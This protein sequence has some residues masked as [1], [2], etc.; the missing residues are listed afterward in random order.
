MEFLFTWIEKY[1]TIFLLFAVMSYMIPQETYRK[2][3]RFFMELVFVLLLIAPIFSFFFEG[4]VQR[5]EHLPLFYGGDGAEGEGG[6]EPILSG[7]R[8]YGVCDA[9]AGGGAGAG[10]R[11]VSLKKAF[12]YIRH[13]DKT[14]WLTV[15]LVGVLLLVVA[16]PVNNGTKDG[17]ADADGEEESAAESA[18]REQQ[19]YQEYLEQRLEDIL[20]TM[21]GVGNVRV[22]ITVKDK[23]EKVV[24]KDN[25]T[26]NSSTTSEDGLVSNDYSSES[27]TVY[28]GEDTP[29]ETKELL[30]EVEGVVVVAEGAGNAA[31]E[32]EIYETVMAL[33]E[34]DAH[35]ISVGKMRLQEGT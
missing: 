21:D 2:Y 31:V 29:Y 16:I 20:K 35:K 30:P 28:D 5:A 24:A 19:E 22:M 27:T 10:G 1:I 34:V 14:Q 6:G 13:M 32:T 8:V 4:K 26:S 7:R 18:R 33:F 11:T 17:K 12:N 9:R 25:T 15:I 23:G 3:I